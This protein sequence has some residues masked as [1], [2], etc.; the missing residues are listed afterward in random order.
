M[1]N[2]LPNDVEAYNHFVQSLRT[3][4]QSIQA[5]YMLLPIAGQ[6]LPVYRERVY[7]YELYHQLRLNWGAYRGYSLGGEVD[8]THHPL[9]QD[10]EIRNAKPDLLVHRPGDMG[11]N[12]IIIEVKPVTAKKSGIRKDL[13]TLTAFRHPEKGKYHSA[14]YLVYGGNSSALQAFLRKSRVIQEEDVDDKVALNA[15]TLFWHCLPGHPA[16]QIGWSSA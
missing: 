8:K 15:I 5:G 4:T 6:V 7:C 13:R 3:A 1:P 2:E 10:P 16:E 14:I 11:G 9:F 12:L